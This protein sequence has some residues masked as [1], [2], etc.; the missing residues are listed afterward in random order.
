MKLIRAPFIY[1][2]LVVLATGSI[3]CKKVQEDIGQQ[4]IIKIMTN[5]RWVVEKFTENDT[6]DITAMFQGYEFEFKEDGKVYGYYETSQKQGTWS[7]NTTDL[8]ITSSFA[9]ADDPL[10]KLNDVW[11]LSNNT[12]K[13]VE[14]RPFNS[15]RVAFL[16]LVK[17]N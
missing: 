14:A 16:K 15:N 11:K 5:G 2:L 3:S 17:K 4:F 1:M 8:T 12:S 10:K 13:S 6:D 9:G 7:G